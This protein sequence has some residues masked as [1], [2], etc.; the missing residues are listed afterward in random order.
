MGYPL[1]GA[2]GVTMNVHY[3]NA[4]SQAVTPKVTIII[5]P[6]KAGTVTTRVGTLFLNN[7]AINVPAGTAKSN[8]IAVTGNDVPIRDQDYT[9]FTNWSHM[10]QYATDFQASANGKAFYDEKQWA[11]PPLTTA[12][13]GVN[14]SPLLPLKVKAGT[15]IS[16]TCPYYNPSSQAMTFGDSAQTDDMCIYLG[17]Y[18]PAY[19]TPSSNSN[20]P[21]IL[22]DTRQ[23]N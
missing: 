5:Y 10:H 23:P 22:Y 17:Q 20:Y 2:N 8:P 7:R 1:V 14:Q 15:Q 3:L 6:A 9:I 12:G 13:T 19:G 16:W 18:Y 4:S 11:E 21:D